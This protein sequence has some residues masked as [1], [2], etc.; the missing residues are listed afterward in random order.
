VAAYVHRPLGATRRLEGLV[1][2][3]T[4]V[5]ATV[6]ATDLDCPTQISG[7]CSVIAGGPDAGYSVSVCPPQP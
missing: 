1:G 7:S 6:C 4:A 2:S 5:D 3:V